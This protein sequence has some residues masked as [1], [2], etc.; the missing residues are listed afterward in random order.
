MQP[1]GEGVLRAGRGRALGSALGA[2]LGSALGGGA[3]GSETTTDALGGGVG[4]AKTLA[5]GTV[6]CFGTRWRTNAPAASAVPTK[7][8]GMAISHNGKVRCFCPASVVSR[9]A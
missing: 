8:M 7:P 2:A 4:T 9:A 6:S 1:P 3:G 5:L